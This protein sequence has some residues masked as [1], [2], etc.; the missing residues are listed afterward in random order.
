MK[1]AE[2]QNILYHY[3]NVDTLYK[4][5]RTKKLRL[6]NGKKM[7][8]YMEF[9]WIV[10]IVNEEFKKFRYDDTKEYI[11]KLAE[12]LNFYG[13]SVPYFFC[14]SEEG[15]L[16]S[17]WRSYA[18]NGKG[19]AIGININKLNINPDIPFVGLPKSHSLGYGRIIYDV[20]EQHDLIN[21]IL[22]DNYNKIKNEKKD[23]ELTVVE[24]VPIIQKLSAVFKNPAF[25]EEKEWRIIHT[26]MIFKDKENKSI[27]HGNISNIDFY[28]RNEDICSYFELD[29]S[30][31][32]NNGLLEEIVL[33]PR[34]KLELYDLGLFLSD[35]SLNPKI[36]KSEA[37]YR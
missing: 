23:L 13:E 7:N 15:D 19:V 28:V 34:T 18:D 4:I 29:I 14:M 37:S 35:L 2:K 11:D 30:E 22:E 9:S 36:I 21:K 16:L 31:A 10:S 8:D 12:R 27:F 5:L 32:L 26:P 3:C 6:T 20:T 1:E 17:Q 24:T 33:G 25:S